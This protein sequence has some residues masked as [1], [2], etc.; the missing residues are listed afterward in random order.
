MVE[1]QNLHMRSQQFHVITGASGGG[2]STLIAA[3]TLLPVFASRIARDGEV[4]SIR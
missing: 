2:K 1:H 3:L 4:P